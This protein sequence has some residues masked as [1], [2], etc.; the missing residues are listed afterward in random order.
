MDEPFSALDS[1]TRKNLRKEIK[2]LKGELCI[3]IIHVTHD[4]SEA[5]QLGDEL[6]P[7]VQ[8][9]IVPRWLLQFRLKELSFRRRTCIEDIW[10]QND[11]YNDDLEV[12]SL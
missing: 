7:I 1:V 6:L 3:P 2:Q 11:T 10:E 9:R 5:T 8:G 12:S 4:I